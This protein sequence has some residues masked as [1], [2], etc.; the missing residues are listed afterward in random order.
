MLLQ[1]AKQHV[2]FGASTPS[3]LT[4]APFL[5]ADFAIITVSLQSSVTNGSL[6]TIIGT[7]DD[8]LTKALGT[9]SQTINAQ[10][11]SILTTLTAAGQYAIT[12]GVRWINAFRDPGWGSA[13]SNATLKIGRAHV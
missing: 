1:I 10:G 8:G 2:C 7:N 5:C 13:G 4:G 12:P 6:C 11:W 3:T 9:P